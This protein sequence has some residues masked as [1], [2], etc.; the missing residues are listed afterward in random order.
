MFMQICNLFFQTGFDV[1]ALSGGNLTSTP[2]VSE[3]LTE[4]T[5]SVIV[6]VEGEVLMF[7]GSSDG[8]LSKV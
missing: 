6:Q 7:A 3:S 2:V 8:R 1:V 5:S 4:F